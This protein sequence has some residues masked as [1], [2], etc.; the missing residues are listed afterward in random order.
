MV[1]VL[2]ESAAGVATITLNR[3]AQRNAMTPTLLAEL[4]SACESVAGDDRVRAVVLTGAGGSFCVGADLAE[5]SKRPFAEGDEAQQ[6]ADLIETSRISLLLREMPKVTVAAIDG[7]CAGAGMGLAMAADLRVC[8][9][10]AV[11]R[12][13]FAGAGMS[14]DFGLVWSLGNLLGDAMARR[15]LLTDPKIRADEALKL[16]LVGEIGSSERAAQLAGEMA[17]RAPLAVAGI[18]QNLADSRLG[19]ADALHRESP[20][21][22]RCARSEDALEAARAFMEK[23]PPRWAGR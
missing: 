18:K 15:L 2:M 4:L 9:P 1:E 22:I 10:K 16:N 11:F 7:A 23:R 20:R 5:L 6:I 8:T 17:Q 12:C 21:H 19:F 3:P 13:A 14:G